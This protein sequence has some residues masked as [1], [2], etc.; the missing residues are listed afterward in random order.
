MKRY[1]YRRRHGYAALV[2]LIIAVVSA[3]V[4]HPQTA[5]RLASAQPGLWHVYHDVD[6]DTID[7][8]Q[9]STREIVRF[10]GL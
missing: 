6:G 7:V 3:L 2:G 9:G 8:E 10:S 4:S 5:Q 1:R